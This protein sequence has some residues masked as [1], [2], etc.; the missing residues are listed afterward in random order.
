[1]GH[2]EGGRMG[3]REGRGV[4]MGVGGSQQ[5]AG[6]GCGAGEDGGG[7]DLK[8]SNPRSQFANTTHH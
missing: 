6:G 2:G 4:A 8:K 1:M 3:H 5:T 7:D